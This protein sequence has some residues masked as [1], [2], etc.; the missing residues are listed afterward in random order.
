METKTTA[1]KVGDERL[2]N[3]ARAVSGAEAAEAFGPNHTNIR[4]ESETFKAGVLTM[5][6]AADTLELPQPEPKEETDDTLVQ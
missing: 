3:E 6:W 2:L 4:V 1:V 5:T